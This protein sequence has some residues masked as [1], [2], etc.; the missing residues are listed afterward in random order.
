[1]ACMRHARL[2]TVLVVGCAGLSAQTAESLD[3]TAVGRDSKWKVAGRTTSVVEEKGKRALKVSEGPG[4][5]LVWLDGYQFTNGTIEVDILGRSQPVQG[6]FVGV[7]FRIADPKTHDAVYFRPFNFRAADADRKSHS[8]QY[9]S[10]PKWSWQVLR[11][12]HPGQ[13]EKPIV[14]APDGDPGWS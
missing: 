9:V 2:F 10:E 3:I 4:M 1:M 14:P 6:S 12:Q 11:S 8:V 5:G 13:Y 7:A